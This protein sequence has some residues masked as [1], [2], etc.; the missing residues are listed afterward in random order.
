MPEVSSSQA[1]RIIRMSDDTVRRHVRMGLLPARRQ[2][3][4]KDAKIEIEELRRFAQK[5]NYQFDEALAQSFS[6]L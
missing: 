1:A 2:G 6:T 3:P 5:Y 4:R